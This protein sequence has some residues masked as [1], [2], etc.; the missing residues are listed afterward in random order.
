MENHFAGVWASA[1][2]PWAR[3]VGREVV[4]GRRRRF[5]ICGGATGSRCCRTGCLDLPP[6]RRRVGGSELFSILAEGIG[7]PRRPGRAVKNVSSRFLRATVAGDRRLRRGRG[8]RFDGAVVLQA[9]A[10]GSAFL[11]DR[12]YTQQRPAGA[13]KRLW[14]DGRDQS[15]SGGTPG[16]MLRRSPAGGMADFGHRRNRQPPTRWRERSSILR[17]GRGRCT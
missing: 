9:L 13:C 11:A 4:Q 5:G 2:R 1:P 10:G 12:R 15:R 6:T 3:V 8:L 14:R 16:R 7:S 17:T